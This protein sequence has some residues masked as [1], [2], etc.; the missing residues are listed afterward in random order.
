MQ[1]G[2]RK[3]MLPEG[4]VEAL[5]Q[6]AEKL[7]TLEQVALSTFSGWGYRPLRPPM[8]EY[9]DTFVSDNFTGDLAEQTLQFKDQKSGRQ[10]GLRADITPQIARIDAHY[11]KTDKVAR[12]A[13][14][15]EVVRSYPTGHGSARNPTIAGAEILG[16]A[17]SQ[18]DIEIVNLLIAFLTAVDL[19]HFIIELGSVDIV[20]TL[21]SELAV[22][23]AQYPRFFDALVKKDK[24]KLI[25]LAVSNGVDTQ[26][27]NLLAELTN[28][29]GDTS[30]LDAAEQLFSDYPEV[31]KEIYLLK[32]TVN[33]L[34]Q[35]NPAISLHLDLSDVRGYGYHN[36]LIFSAYV[37]GVWQ[38]IARGGRYDSFGNQFGENA[39]VRPSTGFSCHL[40]LLLPLLDADNNQRRIIACPTVGENSRHDN[41]LAQYVANLRSQG[42]VVIALFDDNTVPLSACSHT[43]VATADGYAV[44]EITQPI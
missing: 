17:S 25:E 37:E 4:V 11:L 40:N 19:P 1:S 35:Q 41:T 23:E 34:Q 33:S 28:M 31:V 6:D 10:L 16:S 39:A 8:L 12:Y 15:G 26:Q 32:Q 14:V 3:W 42:D 5:P 7:N 24:E 44:A 22:S 9:A 36:G 38:A 27:A 2:F 21:L 20:V 29:Y 13:Y 43:I 30:V 18:A